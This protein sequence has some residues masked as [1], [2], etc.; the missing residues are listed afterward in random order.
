MW[1]KIEDQFPSFVCGYP[2]AHLLKKTV[3]YSLCSLGTIVEDHLTIK[4]VMSRLSNLFRW[5]VCQY[6][7]FYPCVL[8]TTAFWYIL[9]SVSVML[10]AF[11]PFSRLIWLFKV[12]YT[13]IWILGFF[14]N[15]YKKCLY[16]LDRNDIE[17]RNCYGNMNILIVLLTYFTIHEHRISSFVCSLI[18]FSSIL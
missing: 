1:C 17:S 15:F 10:P 7:C 13:C 16:D 12:F 8:I 18:S 5:S 11:S 4:H 9:K 14:L 2:V 3:L 6:L